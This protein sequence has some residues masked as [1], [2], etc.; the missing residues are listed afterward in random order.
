[1]CGTAPAERYQCIAVHCYLVFFRMIETPDQTLC[2]KHMI[3]QW[4]HAWFDSFVPRSAAPLN[5][6]LLWGF[7][8]ASWL[9]LQWKINSLRAVSSQ[10]HSLSAAGDKR[11]AA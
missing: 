11:E 9:R 6:L 5:A 2:A 8:L 10:N 3:G 4:H 1:M 7:T